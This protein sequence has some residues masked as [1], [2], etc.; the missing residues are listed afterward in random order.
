MRGDENWTDVN[1]IEHQAWEAFGLAFD[2]WLTSLPP[3]SEVH[4]MDYLHEKVAAY[5]AAQDKP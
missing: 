3:D 2:A 4:D 5:W 1:E